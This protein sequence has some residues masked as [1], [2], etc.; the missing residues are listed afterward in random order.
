MDEDLREKLIH[1]IELLKKNKGSARGVCKYNSSC[2]C[3][4]CMTGEECHYHKTFLEK[5]KSTHSLLDDYIRAEISYLAFYK[6]DGIE[7]KIQD[8]INRYYKSIYS[9][10][11]DFL[12]FDKA[13]EVLQS[14]KDELIQ[15]WYINN[16]NHLQTKGE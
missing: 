5:T 10:A 4:E 16:T 2:N 11:I 3:S 12:Q 15:L 7:K 14:M 9:Y 1:E 8:I 13:E 6:E